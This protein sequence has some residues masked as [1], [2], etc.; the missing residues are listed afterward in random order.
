MNKLLALLLTLSATN[1]LAG[2][3]VT[4]DIQRPDKE[5]IVVTNVVELG[6]EVEFDS[7]SE[8]E[9]VSAIET[10][11]AWYHRLFGIEP[12]P[13]ETYAVL[14][15]GFKSRFE[16][17]VRNGDERLQFS[18][19]GQIT[20]ALSA[21]TPNYDGLLHLPIRTYYLNSSHVVDMTDGYGCLEPFFE[22]EEH[23]F[24]V[25]IRAL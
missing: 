21:E 24:N 18:I 15:V 11:T 4:L 6:K 5:P 7:V 9:Y 1:V 14:D 20:E 3:Q 8:T 10:T 12:E 2:Y 16:L 17:S 13:V 23:S 19:S 22:T 25:C